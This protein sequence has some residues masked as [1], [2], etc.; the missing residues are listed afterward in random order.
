[1]TL[2]VFRKDRF[3]ISCYLKENK[4]V[5]IE[6]KKDKQLDDDEV[7]TLLEKNSDG[8]A[9]EKKNIYQVD[10]NKQEYVAEKLKLE[11]TYS[12]LKKSLLISSQEVVNER[13]EKKKKDMEGF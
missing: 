1:M 2:C 12:I 7:K 11:A 13:N 6:Y 10:L 5:A 8:S 3:Q 9:W 4:V